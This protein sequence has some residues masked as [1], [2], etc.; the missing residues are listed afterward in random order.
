[1]MR[2]AA[3]TGIALALAVTSAEADV[4]SDLAGEWRGGGE[5][6]GMASEQ[7]MRWGP[8]LDGAF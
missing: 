6:R 7:T 4:L 8:V 5:V 3:V 2:L 1:M